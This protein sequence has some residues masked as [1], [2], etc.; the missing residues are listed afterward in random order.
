MRLFVAVDI[1]DETRA[2]LAAARE[3]IRSVLEKARVP[4]RVIWVKDEAAH[5][6]VRFIG[7]MPEEHVREISQALGAGFKAPAFD[8]GWDR[9]GTFPTLRDLGEGRERSGPAPGPSPNVIWLGPASDSARLAR[10]AEAV[11]ER[12]APLIG[13]GESRPFKPHV[14]IARIKDPGK[15]VDWAQALAVRRWMPTTTRVDHV[16]LYASRTTPAGAVYTALCKV[17]M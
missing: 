5:V 2:Q 11:N 16:T 15:G 6:T 9:L 12:L 7:E 10:L 14:T 4:P 8:V 13:G 17:L 3:A 1:D